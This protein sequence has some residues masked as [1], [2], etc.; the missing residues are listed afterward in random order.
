MRR[1]LIEQVIEKPCF[2]QKMSA[3]TTTAHVSSVIDREGYLSARI[4]GQAVSMTVAD[5]QE[6]DIYVYDADA[7]TGTFTVFSSAT[8]TIA[9]QPS[10]SASET[11][12]SSWDGVDVD[13][14]GADR[15]IKVYATVTGATTVTAILSVA[16]L[17]GDGVIEPA[18]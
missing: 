15:Y 3:G 8:A 14:I 10:Y 7:I 1:K 17:L 6:F 18:V 12:A 11:G 5:T 4:A 9:I 16:C 2:L 13:L